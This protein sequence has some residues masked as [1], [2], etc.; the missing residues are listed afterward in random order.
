MKIWNKS[1][2]KYTQS[3]RRRLL[4]LVTIYWNDSSIEESGAFKPTVYNVVKF[5][6][7]PKQLKEILNTMFLFVLF[8]NMLHLPIAHKYSIKLLLF[9]FRHLVNWWEGQ[10][11][12][13]F[14]ILADLF[15]WLNITDMC[16]KLQVKM[17]FQFWKWSDA[18]LVLFCR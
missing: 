6:L 16:M 17:H 4:E 12:F 7:T 14:P 18:Y 3:T 13:W 11:P 15:Q 10:Q 9:D 2:R 8:C 1:P 5:S